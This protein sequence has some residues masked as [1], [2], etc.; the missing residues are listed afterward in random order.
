MG[1]ALINWVN[2][3]ARPSNWLV[4]IRTKAIIRQA[5]QSGKPVKINIGCGRTRLDKT[6]LYGDMYVDVYQRLPF[7]DNT[8]D[9]MFSEHFIEHLPENRIRRF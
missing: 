6:W 7:D 8:V 2:R 1:S 9:F 4:R 5:L 3:I